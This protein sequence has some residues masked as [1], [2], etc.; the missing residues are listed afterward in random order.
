[1]ASISKIKI[2]NDTR[3]I[4][5]IRLKTASNIKLTGAVT[6]NVSFTSPLTG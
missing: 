5:A 6:G 2:G 1:M 3:D 4:Y